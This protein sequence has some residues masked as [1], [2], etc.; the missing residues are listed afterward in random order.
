MIVV[1]T[2]LQKVIASEAVDMA[3][4]AAREAIKKATQIAKKKLRKMK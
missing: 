4:K 3:R 1:K 2:L